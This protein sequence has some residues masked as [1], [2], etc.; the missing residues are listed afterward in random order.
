MAKNSGSTDTGAAAFE[1][2]PPQGVP[3]EVQA[4]FLLWLT[5]VAAGVLETIIRVIESLSVARAA[6]GKRTSPAWPSG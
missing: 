5:A 4:S 1:P 3:K 2:G 6:V